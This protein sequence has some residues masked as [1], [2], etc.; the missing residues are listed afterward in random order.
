MPTPITVTLSYKPRVLRPLSTNPRQAAAP[1]NQFEFSPDTNP[2][3]VKRGQTIHFQT[4]SVPAGGKLQLRFSVPR[5][6]STGRAD[7]KQTG[8]FFDGDGPVTVDEEIPRGTSVT[9]HCTLLVNGEIVGESH[10]AGGDIMP[11]TGN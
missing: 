3:S 1:E 5:F 11:A 10:E 6:F 9:Y 7:F 4:G 8:Q 2:I